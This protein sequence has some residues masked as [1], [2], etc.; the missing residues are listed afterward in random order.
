MG[1]GNF[2]ASVDP[3]GKVILAPAILFLSEQTGEI[4]DHFKRTKAKA[5]T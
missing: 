4:V 1:L 3:N 2:L 5:N